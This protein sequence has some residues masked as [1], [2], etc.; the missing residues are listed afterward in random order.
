L[1]NRE[2]KDEKEPRAAD[3]LS[4]VAMNGYSTPAGE[5]AIERLV[6][7]YPDNPAIERVCMILGRGGAPN[8]EKMLRQLLEKSTAPKVKA[9]AA[10]ALGQAL[11]SKTDALGD[12]PAE[13]DKFAAEA[14]K[15]FTQAIDL[16]KDNADQKAEAEHE[17]KALRTLRVGKEAPE[18]AAGDLD[19]K[20]FK[21]SDY[22]GKVVMLDFWGN[23]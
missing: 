21:L 14:E 20:E 6:E 1:L 23:W 13:A 11:V 18:I 22:R 8:A 5:K 15:Y 9:M 16:L 12:K 10:L 7:K 17:L 2:E 19:G 3:L 4:W